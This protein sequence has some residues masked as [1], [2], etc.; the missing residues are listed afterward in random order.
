MGIR[1]VNAAFDILTE[2]IDSLIPEIIKQ[3]NLLNESRYFDKARK[4]IEQAESMDDFKADILHLKQQWNDLVS[5]ISKNLGALT[6]DKT[7]TVQVETEELEQSIVS[8]PSSPLSSGVYL[9]GQET[10]NAAKTNKSVFYIPILE[11]LER[12]YGE[13][14]SD[15]LFAHLEESLGDTLTESDRAPLSPGNPQI[16]WHN[17]V[18]W[19]RKE[20]VKQGLLEDTIQ[21]KYWEISNL[22]RDHFK[23]H[24]IAD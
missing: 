19:A 10:E 11:V 2:E 22:G 12:N 18:F 8:I 3:G 24:S 23:R 4:V 5:T 17:S 14:D 13:I 15:T 1:E 16:R 9:S 7:A 21:T 6:T 20:L